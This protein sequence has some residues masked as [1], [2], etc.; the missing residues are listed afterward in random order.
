ML[1]E[2]EPWRFDLF[3]LDLEERDGERFDFRFF[4]FRFFRRFEDESRDDSDSLP[5][6][7]TPFEPLPAVSSSDP[8]GGGE[9]HCFRT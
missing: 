2:L 9:H 7:E 4:E 1:E 3:P 5:S 6:S 8:P